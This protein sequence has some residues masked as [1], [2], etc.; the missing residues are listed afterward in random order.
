MKKKMLSGLL[1]ISM[2]VSCF[3][4][5][6]G[7][8]DTNDATSNEVS[9]SE[10][11]ADSENEEV[12]GVTALDLMKQYN[13]ATLNVTDDNYRTF[14]EI[15]VY[16]YYD[17][18]GDGI[19][20][21]NGLTSKLDYLNDGDDT[22]DT[23]LGINGIWLMPIMPSPTYHKYDVM[24]YMNIDSS[25]G[26]LEDFDA[27]IAAC[28]ERGINVIID[29]V[30]NHSS[31]QHEWFKT[32]CEYLQSLP[33]GAEPDATECPYVA[34]YNF[35]K[36][37]LNNYYQVEGTEWYYEG[38]FWSEMPDM[39]LANEAVRAE[40][41]AIM[42]FWIEHGVDGFRIDA[43]KEF[44]T[45]AD[46]KNIEVLTWL[47]DTAKSLKEDAFVV[48]EVWNDM[49]VYTKYHQSGSSI[50]DFV[51]A[52]K[53]GVIANTLRGS[54]KSG[55]SAYGNQIIAVQDA[56]S[57]YNEDYIDA[58]FYTNHDMGR[59]AGY[60]AG[61]DSTMQTKM[62]QAMNLLMSGSAFIYY[63]E[64]L[65]MKGAGKDENKRAPMYWSTD[66]QAEGMCAGP[67]GM[68]SIKMKYGSYE[69]QKEDGNSVYNY[70]KQV[71]RLRNQYNT[72]SHG[73]TVLEED[74]SNENLCTIRKMYDDEEVV[75]IFN[76]STETQKVDI[77]SLT[78]N[79]RIG[80]E[81][82]I[83]GV[84]LSGTEDIEYEG[85]ELVMPEYSVVVLK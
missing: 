66:S 1:A 63:G 26:T 78:A 51:F 7:K 38:Q 28:H 32:A 19:G 23:D 61:D 83:G 52:D 24:D 25:Y 84:L 81:L 47:N 42:A 30:V 76:I 39:N 80:A 27:F 68:E 73:Y 82:E 10:Q 14:Y 6:C 71:I 36:E 75:I 34:Y 22:T 49:S 16:S 48:A 31:S 41:E 58:P 15:F 74:L 60:Y 59:S 85:N 11:T 4:A 2:L 53:D 56:M 8:N 40:Y 44:Y 43:A 67:V 55:A 17:S 21:F 70:V 79:E 62:A 29:L 13:T 46:D 9:G 65:G 5:G 3:V 37:K 18:N 20:D 50:F 45:G 72:I 64:E 35:S 33:E 77:S 69:E 12:A 57:S 54:T